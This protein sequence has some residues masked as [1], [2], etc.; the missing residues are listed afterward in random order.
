[1]LG[2]NPTAKHHVAVAQFTLCI[3][4]LLQSGA[5]GGTGLDRHLFFL[6]AGENDF[7]GSLLHLVTECMESREDLIQVS[8]HSDRDPSGAPTEE[9]WTGED[10]YQLTLS[11]RLNAIAI[12][13]VRHSRAPIARRSV[14]PL[15]VGQ[16]QIYRSKKRWP[17]RGGVGRGQQCICL[18][19]TAHEV[20]V[21]CCG[22][23][24]INSS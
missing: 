18:L 4:L 12:C 23:L 7:G 16:V 22:G 14:H 10:T 9:G 5:V 20:S 24:S 15:N 2:L 3:E 8:I 19:R 21:R 6:I 13:H 11:L 1:L 17:H